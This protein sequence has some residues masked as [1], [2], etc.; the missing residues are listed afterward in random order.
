MDIRTLLLRPYLRSSVK[1]ST[2]I[3]LL[4]ASVIGLS[5]LAMIFGVTMTNQGAVEQ[6]M[7]RTRLNQNIRSAMDLI[8][9]DVRQ[10]GERLPSSLPAVELINGA[11]TANDQLLLRRNLIDEVL[12]VCQD[13][14]AGSTGN[15]IYLSTTAAGASPACT[16][17]GQ[18]QNYTT[19]K[20][21]RLAHKNSVK[22]YIYNMST[23]LGEFISYTGE[24]DSGVTLSIQK[25]AGAFVNA[26]P[27]NISA[28]YIMSEL[29]YRMSADPTQPDVLEQVENKEEDNVR[30]VTFGL[31]TFQL[32]AILQDGTVKNSMTA[33]DAWASL[34]SI[35]L[36]VSGQ[37][38]IK[39]RTIA[40]TLSSR[41]FPRNILS[42]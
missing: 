3:E 22:V 17:G 33:S 10:A 20:N 9:A 12:T 8:A 2:L 13:I 38:K 27:K 30:K 37:Q 16:Y 42:L 18:T 28:V 5:M 14:S 35:S 29:R 36:T 7:R 32:Q 24:N 11:G 21:Y 41:F 26:Y 39:G 40:T 1:G 31:S 4:V 23:R 34:A 6:D 25:Q 15:V 19:W